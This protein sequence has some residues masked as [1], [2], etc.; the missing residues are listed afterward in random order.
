[1]MPTVSSMQLEHSRRCSPVREGGVEP[2]RPFGHWNLNP[3]RLPIPPPARGCRLWVP[4]RLVRAPSDMQKISTLGRVPSHPYIRPRPPRPASRRPRSA[5]CPR[6]HRPGTERTPALTR[7][8]P[9]ES[10]GRT[11]RT[12]RRTNRAGNP[13]GRTNERTNGPTDRRT[14]QRANGQTGGRAEG[15]DS[16]RTGKRP[17]G[18][19]VDGRRADG[20]REDGRQRADRTVDSTDGWRTGRRTG[21]TAGE[22]TADRTDDRRAHAAKW[23]P[24]G[25][26]AV[27]DGP[28]ERPGAP[29]RT[30]P[31]SSPSCPNPAPAALRSPGMDLSARRVRDTGSG[32]PLRSPWEQVVEVVMRPP[33]RGR[34]S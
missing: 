30:A 22:R 33:R 7:S 27:P 10:G 9:V 14:G 15:P 21:P 5:P 23:R 16:G 29:R 3:A 31:P 11:T 25:P 4:H 12:T 26:R 17:D 34:G 6:T 32:A 1:M 28:G 8:S 13:E 20:R 19:T 2:P 24:G 18:R